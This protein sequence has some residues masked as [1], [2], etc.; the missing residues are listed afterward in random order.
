[1]QEAQADPR[2]L[3][4]QEGH[5]MTAR[6]E[7]II[8]A[9]VFVLMTAGAPTPTPLPTSVAPMPVQYTRE[10][11]AALRPNRALPEGSMIRQAM[12]DYRVE[13]AALQ[14]LHKLPPPAPYPR[15]A[16]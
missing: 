11:T 15:P 6:Y 14:A 10:Q 3:R 16:S 7:R 8:V 4:S 5:S 13:R 1:M 12:D 2:G 9:P